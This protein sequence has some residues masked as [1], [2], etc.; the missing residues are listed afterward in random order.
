MKS[1]IFLT[2]LC[3]NFTQA[4]SNVD[5]YKGDYDA[6]KTNPMKPCEV[7]IEIDKGLK[8]F[9]MKHFENGS[10]IKS[11]GDLDLSKSQLTEMGYIDDEKRYDRIATALA[12]KSQDLF[13]KIDFF[14][15]NK[16][17]KKVEIKTVNLGEVAMG[18]GTPYMSCFGLEKQP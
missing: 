18:G 7:K 8:G 11:T 14:L 13:F 1:L 10:V 9:S 5:V 2:F 4:A 16:V 3:W 6:E 17:V 12:R 15:L